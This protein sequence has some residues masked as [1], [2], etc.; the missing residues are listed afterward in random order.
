MFPYSE[1]MVKNFLENSVG[2]DNLLYGLK[3]QTTQYPPYDIKK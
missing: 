3:E 1:S 2:F